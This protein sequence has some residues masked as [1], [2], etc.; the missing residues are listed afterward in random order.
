MTRIN[1]SIPGAPRPGWFD[2]SKAERFEEATR[3][4]GQNSV[5]VVAPKFHHEALYR[6]KGGRW[7]LNRWSQ[8]Q[9]SEDVYRFISDEQAKTWLIRNERDEDVKRFFGELEPERGPGRPAIG[10]PLLIRLEPAQRAKL[11]SLARPGEALAAVV[12]RLIDQA[13]E[14]KED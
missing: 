7:V 12:R 4:D 5:S 13:Q 3:W 8:W 9:G 11:E 1:V 14:R 6:T 2:L 10:D